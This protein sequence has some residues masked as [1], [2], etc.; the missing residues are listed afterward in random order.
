ML[1]CQMRWDTQHP[2]PTH[3]AMRA[4]STI[5]T[6]SSVHSWLQ[7]GIE[8]N[9][10]RVGPRSIVLNNLR[11]YQV[12]V[13]V[14]E[15]SSGLP[16]RLEHVSDKQCKQKNNATS[17]VFFGQ[18]PIAYYNEGCARE[19]FGA[20]WQRQADASFGEMAAHEFGHHVLRLAAPAGA[21]ILSF[22]ASQLTQGQSWSWTHKNT[23]TL[24]QEALDTSPT[25]PATGD[26]DIMLF[27]KG[28]PP[29]GAFGRSFASE[30]DVRRLVGLA[31]A[32]R[33]RGGAFACP[34]EQQQ[35]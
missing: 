5:P 14:Q 28:T 3:P 20:G 13:T 16:F 27:Y 30:D 26:W 4:S 24:T 23:S 11:Q 12:V 2:A 8:R 9:W 34:L 6:A 22:G 7:A 18:D 25:Y 31:K 21:P 1:C 17:I 19:Q 29:R 32:K 35:N 15:R 33:A 10:S